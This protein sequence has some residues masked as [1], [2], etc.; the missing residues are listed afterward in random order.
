[1]RESVRDTIDAPAEVVFACVVDIT[2]LPDWNTAISEIVE[3][4]SELHAGSVWKVRLRAQRL[5]WVSKST[6]TALDANSGTFRYRSQSD[7]GNPSYA[8]WEWTVL[9]NGSVSEVTVSVDLHPVTF[10][11][12]YVLVR[13]R[14]PALRKE[15]RR[16]LAALATVATR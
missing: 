15:M 3:V 16:S 2:R 7:D 4:P 10:W 14:R 12:K 6:V 13:L 5:S 1:M 8:D 11:R 9:P